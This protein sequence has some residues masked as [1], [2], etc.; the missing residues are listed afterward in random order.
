M[1]GKGGQGK[2]G[3]LGVAS[4]SRMV[5]LLPSGFDTKTIYISNVLK[6][7]FECNHIWNQDS[8]SLICKFVQMTWKF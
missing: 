4:E 5:I 2:E 1:E 6:V 3:G 8:V 7:E